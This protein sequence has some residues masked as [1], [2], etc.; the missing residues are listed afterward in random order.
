MKGRESGKRDRLGV[1]DSGSETRLLTR[2]GRPLEEGPGILRG[3]SA[4][5]RER[6][7]AR[8]EPPVPDVP[9]LVLVPAPVPAPVPELMPE[10]LIP[11]PD[12]GIE[13]EVP[14]AVAGVR[15]GVGGVGLL[16]LGGSTG[17]QGRRA[18]MSAS[19]SV[20]GEGR[21]RC[22]APC[23]PGG[24]TGGA[25]DPVRTLDVLRSKKPVKPSRRLSDVK[26]RSS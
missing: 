22:C 18:V 20:R 17:C 25:V 12:G 15:V 23:T 26:P 4:S 13:M 19:M 7:A 21:T 11:E 1:A 10:L 9:M 24:S 3:A 16:M 2:M 5:F 6:E 8:E 14:V